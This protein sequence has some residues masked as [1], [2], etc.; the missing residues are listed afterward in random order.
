[1]KIEWQNSVFC[2]N[3]IKWK[4]FIKNF[5]QICGAKSNKWG[6]FYVEL[7]L[8][9]YYWQNKTY[10]KVHYTVHYLEI[11]WAQQKSTLL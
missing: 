5:Y 4:A 3:V 2:F 11:V 8:K 9:R 10:L 7:L 1:M 6:D